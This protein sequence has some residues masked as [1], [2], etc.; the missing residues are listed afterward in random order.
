MLF[1][2]CCVPVDNWQGTRFGKLQALPSNGIP[3]TL[4]DN[5]DAAFADVSQAIRTTLQEIQRLAV[6]TPSTVLPRIW[7]IPYPRNPMFTGREEICDL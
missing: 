1:L 5:Q 7:S 3:I 2:Y 6:S 4:W